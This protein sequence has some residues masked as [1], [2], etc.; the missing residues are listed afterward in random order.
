ASWVFPPSK[1]SL[2][3]SPS[4]LSYSPMAFSITSVTT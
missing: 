4:S 2:A 3:S 1:S